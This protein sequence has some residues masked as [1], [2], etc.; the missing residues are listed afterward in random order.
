[1]FNVQNAK[2]I[3]FMKNLI[4]RI[5]HYNMPNY[6]SHILTS[7]YNDNFI[8]M[9]VIKEK[10]NYI[11]SYDIG[12]YKKINL[13]KLNF[14]QKIDLLLAICRIKREN[15]ETLIPASE[16]LIEP[17][18]IYSIDENSLNGMKMIFYPDSQKLSFD[19]KIYLFANRIIDVSSAKE[20]LFLKSFNDIAICRNTTGILQFL[21]KTKRKLQEAGN[22]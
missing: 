4:Q 15:E 10:K 9:S 2:E 16:Y 3:N 13:K 1:M 5:N 18:L 17:E 21:Y 22:V 8:K 6:L 19:K 11:F 14:E 7:H 12:R 20:L